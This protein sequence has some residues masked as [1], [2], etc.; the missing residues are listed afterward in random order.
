MS[1]IRLNARNR[2]QGGSSG[3]EKLSILVKNPPYIKLVNAR[4]YDADRLLTKFT[5]R[6]KGQI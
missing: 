4:S 5:D 3:D 6:K 2:T 1:D